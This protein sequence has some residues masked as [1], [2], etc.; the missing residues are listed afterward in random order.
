MHMKIKKDYETKILY[1][2]GAISESDFEDMKRKL[3]HSKIML[4]H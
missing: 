1:N 4:S 2:Q 3:E